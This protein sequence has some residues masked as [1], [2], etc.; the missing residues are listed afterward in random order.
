MVSNGCLPSKGFVK[1][2]E[3]PLAEFLKSKNGRLYAGKPHG[4]NLKRGD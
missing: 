1:Q 3:I 4:G 2:E